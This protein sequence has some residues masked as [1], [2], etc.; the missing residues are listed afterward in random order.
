MPNPV[1]D[2][3]RLVR[4][5]EPNS[6]ALPRLE[7]AVLRALSVPVPQDLANGVPLLR[8]AEGRDLAPVRLVDAVLHPPRPNPFHHFVC[9]VDLSPAKGSNI[10]W[11]PCGASVVEL[12]VRGLVRDILMHAAPNLVWF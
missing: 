4:W 6:Q 8:Y 9:D 5:I 11:I 12:Q 10:I 7:S 2:G 1:Q 3:E